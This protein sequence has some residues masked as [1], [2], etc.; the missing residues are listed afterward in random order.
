MDRLDNI[1]TEVREERRYQD[2]RW[3]HE[4]D[5]TKNTPWMWAAYIASYAT[6]WMNG[7]F[8]PIGE[9]NV[10]NFRKAMVKAAAIAVAAIESIDRQTE[11][12]GRPF[13]Q[14]A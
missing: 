8:P 13:Y 11:A 4:V 6:S 3:G 1:L 2:T 12:N 9:D 10:R 5:D 14:A 7:S